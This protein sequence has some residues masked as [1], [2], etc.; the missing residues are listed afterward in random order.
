LSNERVHFCLETFHSRLLSRW[1]A[2]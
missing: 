2:L 1:A